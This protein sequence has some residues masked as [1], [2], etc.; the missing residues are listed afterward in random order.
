MPVPSI[1]DNKEITSFAEV[2]HNFQGF[3]H[4]CEVGFDTGN[5]P[6]FRCIAVPGLKRFCE[7]IKL[8]LHAHGVFF[9]S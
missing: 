5:E 1:I 6:G 8:I 4:Q 9:P 7:I 3:L 2:S